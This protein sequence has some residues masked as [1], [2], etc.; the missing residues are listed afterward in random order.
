M[1]L[2]ERER[3]LAIRRNGWTELGFTLIE[4]LVVVA[5]IAI[6]AAMLLPVLARA[7]SKALGIYCLN[8]TKQLDL[9][10]LMYSDDHNGRLAYNLG[11]VSGP[12]RIASDTNLNW[13]DNIMTW[14][15]DSDNTNP[16]TITQAGLGPYVNNSLTSYRCPM[17]KVLSSTQIGAGWSARLRSYSMNAMVGDAGEASVS[18]SNVNN[19]RYVQFFSITS[20]PQPANIF[21]FVE[22]HPDSIDDGYFLNQAYYEE[23]EGGYGHE[24]IDLPASYHNAGASFSFADG[25]SEIHHWVCPSTIWPAQPD[26]LTLPMDVPPDQMTDF[27]WVVG[28]MSVKQ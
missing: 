13:V 18:G 19:P 6:L 25:H 1:N 28:R 23:P 14:G 8:N 3:K 24:W 10:W 7:K 12:R 20:V 5:I 9:G 16:A 15:L 27:Q 21:I 11:G 26:V 22:E 2:L 4:L 17:D